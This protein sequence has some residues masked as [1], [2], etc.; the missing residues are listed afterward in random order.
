[1]PMASISH[2]HDDGSESVPLTTSEVANHRP[3]TQEDKQTSQESASTNETENYPSNLT[4][5]SPN[6]YINTKLTRC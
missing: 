5:P 6:Y 2:S 3:H 4:P 1:M